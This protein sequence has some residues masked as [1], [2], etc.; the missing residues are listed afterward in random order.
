M[1]CIGI[2]QKAHDIL[3]CLV[4]WVLTTSSAVLVGGVIHT[5]LLLLLRAKIS[6][7]KNAWFKESMVMLESSH[8]HLNFH[9]V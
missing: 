9:I 2:V 5:F 4:A 8:C 6:L 3:A 1:F 7:L